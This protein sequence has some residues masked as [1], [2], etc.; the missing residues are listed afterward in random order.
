[1]AQ[2]GGRGLLQRLLL[3]VILV[4]VPFLFPVGTEMGRSPWKCRP[5]EGGGLGRADAESGLAHRQ[6]PYSLLGERGRSVQA[7]ALREGRGA[8][9]PTS[10]ESDALSFKP[11]AAG[12]GPGSRGVQPSLVQQRL[13]LWPGWRGEGARG[14]VE[15]GSRG[16]PWSRH[17][18][19]LF[20]S[21][22]LSS[23]PP[24]VSG[25]S[26]PDL[27]PQGVTGAWKSSSGAAR[28]PF[29]MSDR[30]EQ[31]FLGSALPLVRPETDP[32]CKI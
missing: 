4:K 21:S 12:Q 11:Q 6:Q 19:G 7:R 30:S 2:L 16:S 18:A 27:D 26:C 15:A 9:R 28:G 13:A 8:L 10:S 31:T 20:L 14:E 32:G 3:C 22:A 24:V 17:G 1:M 25:S 29:T 5:G 23:A